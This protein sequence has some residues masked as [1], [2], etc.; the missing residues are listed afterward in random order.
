VKWVINTGRDMSSLM[1]ELERA[2]LPIHPDY[3][4][5]V[6]REIYE[7]RDGKFMG[8]GEWNQACA[9]DHHSLFARVRPDVPML[10]EWI[11]KRFD[12]SIYEDAHSPLCVIAANNRDM[13]EI[14]LR[15]GG[16]CATIPHLAVV[17][18]DVYV[19]F[20]HTAYNKG[21]ALAEISRR[22][23]VRREKVFVAGDH[24]NDLPMLT[25]DHAHFIATPANAIPAVRIRVR[26]QGGYVSSSSHGHGVSEALSHFLDRARN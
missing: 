6:E 5:L 24:L 17:R 11:H 19:R 25:R 3:L 22:L 2:N 15:L 1:E 13:D 9:N 4:V 10:A 8:V 23:G 20:C 18:N 21:S 14:H 26:E 16:Y 12:A 7:R